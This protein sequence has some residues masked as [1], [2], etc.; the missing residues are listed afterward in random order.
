MKTSIRLKLIAYTFLLILIVGGSISLFSIREGQKLILSTYE[1]K[2]RLIT[3]LIAQTLTNDIYFLDTNA[4]RLHVEDTRINPD[5]INI[6]VMDIEGKILSDGTVA[7][8]LSDTKLQSS[9]TQKLIKAKDWISSSEGDLLKIGG[10]VLL[11]DSNVVGYLQIEYT[12]GRLNEILRHTTRVNVL[13]TLLC[14]AFGA[15]LAFLTS[16]IVTKPIR[17]LVKATLEI[18][19]GNFQTR[20]KLSG[21]NEF[22]ILADSLNQ[23]VVELETNT[24]SISRLNNEIRERKKIEEAL[25]YSEQKYKTL[26]ETAPDIISIVDREGLFISLN[27]AF[28]KITDWSTFDWLGKHFS[29][30]IHNEDLPRISEKFAKVLLGETPP[31]FEMR[32][33]SSKGEYLVV[34]CAAKPQFVEGQVV[35]VLGISRDISPRKKAEE[36]LHILYNELEIRV[37]DRTKELAK[38]N[39]L[40]KQKT[41]ELKRSN[42][43]LEQFAYIASHDLQEP[44]Y[45]IQAFIDTLQNQYAERINEDMQLLLDRIKNAAGRMSQLIYDVLE[46]SRV[47]MRAKPF[48]EVDLNLTIQDVLADLEVRIQNCQAKVEVAAFPIIEADKLQMRQLFQNLIA[49]ALKFKRE[50]IEPV[51]QIKSEVLSAQGLLKIYVKDNGIGFEKEYGEKIFAPFQRLHSRNQYEGSGIGLAIC[52]KI[53]SRHHGEIIALSEVNLGTEFIITLPLKSEQN[54]EV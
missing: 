46:F 22:A 45:V 7:N 10:P 48:E 17:T 9:F 40:L 37:K 30:L 43:E 52:Q 23:M 49:N 36:E 8:T 21:D 4:I 3:D 33:R 42:T 12:L 39:Y 2:C 35:G 24:T 26:I 19:K 11:P 34:E 38:S 16:A 18:K 50:D 20:V 44:L 5:I 47:T 29:T 15:G 32:L 1:K 6:Y 54:M 31:V 14:M 41:D 51:I 28:E 53:A 13:I 25:R 27:P